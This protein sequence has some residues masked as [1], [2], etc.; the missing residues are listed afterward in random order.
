MKDNSALSQE[1]E[2]A[3]DSFVEQLQKDQNIIAAFVYGSMVR[4]DVWSESDIDMLIV[5]KDDSLPFQQHWLKD[6]D[7]IIQVDVHSRKN[8]RDWM[9]RLLHG[10]ILHHL[11]ATGNLLFSND[12]TITEY[13]T[14]AQNFGERDRHLG[15]M[16]YAN[17]A[18]G[19][20][21]KVRKNIVHNEDPLTAFWWLSRSM[22]FL[23][24][25]EVLSNGDVPIREVIF[26]ARKYNPELFNKG[27][28]NH[29]QKGTSI[30]SLEEAYELCKEY[31]E[32]RAESLFKPVTSFILEQGGHCG[33]SQIDKH[34]RRK[35]RRDDIFTL[36]N[37]CELL[38][39]L[40][41]I[42]R[43][44]SPLRLTNKSRHEVHEAGYLNMEG[45][46]L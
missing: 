10:S 19:I 3:L 31:I 15:M 45:E 27:Y 29:I 23:A 24:F 35:L 38:A 17:S 22:E 18:I 26:Q 37:S 8:F 30:E 6:G 11:M 9:E 4:G 34:F 32:T 7:I 44:D 20:L 41:I 2:A 5:T 16:V 21:Q 33:I 36:I 12:A 43:M 28:I 42:Q 39:D 40:G 14:D 1:Y 13:H 25:L 46:L